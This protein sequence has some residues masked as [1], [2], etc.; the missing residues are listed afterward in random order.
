M[1]TLINQTVIYKMIFKCSLVSVSLSPP[2][3]E[4]AYLDHKHF[5]H[6]RE[7]CSVCESARYL[8]HLFLGH[9]LPTTRV[10]VMEGHLECIRAEIVIFFSSRLNTDFLLF[11]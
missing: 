11:L 3:F 10:S 7:G 1:N 8:R 5:Y 2:G 4:G 9:S 6:C